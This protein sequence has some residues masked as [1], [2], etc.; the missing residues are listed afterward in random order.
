MIIPLVVKGNV[1]QGDD[2]PGGGILSELREARQSGDLLPAAPGCGLSPPGPRGQLEGWPVVPVCLGRKSRVPGE[3]G[4][5]SP[6]TRTSECLWT[7]RVS[8]QGPRTPK[9]T[10]SWGPRPLSTPVVPSA[11]SLHQ[12]SG[13]CSDS[14]LGRPIWT[15]HPSSVRCPPW[16]ARAVGLPGQQVR[17][18]VTGRGGDSNSITISAH[19]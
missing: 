3:W 15:Q 10:S 2:L 12:A 6:Y 13:F 19:R 16:T 11:T 17:Y 4:R 14:S 5:V 9:S 8:W 18:L 7:S 1:S